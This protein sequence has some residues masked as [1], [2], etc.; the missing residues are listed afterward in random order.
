MNKKA[1]LEKKLKSK[2]RRLHR[3]MDKSFRDSVGLTKETWL[4]FAWR[5]QLKI[6][7]MIDKTGKRVRFLNEVDWT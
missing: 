4:Y 5:P 2:V 1:R 6:E 7:S 3:K